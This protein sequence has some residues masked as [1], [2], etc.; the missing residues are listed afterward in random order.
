MADV[1]AFGGSL[2]A[3]STGPTWDDLRPLRTPTVSGRFPVYPDLTDRLAAPAAHPDPVV[4]HV[5]ATCAGY[6]YATGDTVQATADVVAMIM[7]RMG[8]QRNTTRVIGVSVDAMFI[9][10]TAVLVQSEDGRVVILC[11][12]GTQPMN[13]VNWLTDADV[14]ADRIALTTTGSDHVIPVHAGFYRNVRATRYQV[15]EAL[16]DGLEGQAIDGSGRRP[17]SLQTLYVT[18]HSLGGAMACLM[19]IMLRADRG[20]AADATGGSAPGDT[21]AERLAAIY[22]FGQ[23]MVGTAGLAEACTRDP[24]LAR[25]VL[26]YVYGRDIVPH[27]PPMDTGDYRHVGREFRYAGA[28]HWEES[29]RPSGPTSSLI[30]TAE[31]PVAYFA[32]RIRLLRHLRGLYSIDDHL[33]HHYVSALTPPGTVTEFGD[34]QL[35]DQQ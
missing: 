26:R 33:P 25:N 12:R 32:R 6:A 9:C 31:V 34:F 16:R 18:G 13:L 22:T 8:L 21:L 2:M 20:A 7:S 19:G 17:H 24:S 3:T 1:S 15:V 29:S 30:T 11:Y 4:A 14:Y 28:G 35:A 23:P 10:S 5:L 27:L